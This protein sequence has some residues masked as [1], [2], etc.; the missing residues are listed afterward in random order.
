MPADFSFLWSDDELEIKADDGIVEGGGDFSDTHSGPWVCERMFSAWLYDGILPEDYEVKVDG[1]QTFSVKG[2]FVYWRD[3][4]EAL[5]AGKDLSLKYPPL[6]VWRWEMETPNRL[7]NMSQERDMTEVFGDVLG[8]DVQITSLRSNKH[9]HNFHM[10]ALPLAVQALAMLAGAIKEPIYNYTELVEKIKD[11]GGEEQQTPLIGMGS[12]YAESELW[13]ARADIWAALGES[14]PSKYTVDNAKKRDKSKGEFDTEAALLKQCLKIYLDPSKPIAS[15]VRINDPRAD[16][17][18]ASGVRLKTF[19]VV[20]M[21]R[22]TEDAVADLDIEVLEDTSD[23]PEEWKKTGATQAE[24]LDFV[25]DYTKDMKGPP[26]MI[27][28][29][30]EEKVEELK[31]YGCTVE[32]VLKA[33]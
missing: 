28:K 3:E 14:D 17:Y 20:K 18:N 7:E 25:R 15:L 9:R 29:Q 16:A 23:I 2:S 26:P 31:G 5:Q 21:Y 8:Y 13:R 22:S 6:M 12:E 24:W 4:E 10:I 30:L 19:A 1:I 27:K 11:D 32:D 33:M